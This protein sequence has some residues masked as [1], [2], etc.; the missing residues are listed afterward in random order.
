M[1]E[2]YHLLAHGLQ[3]EPELTAV[4]VARQPPAQAVQPPEVLQKAYRRVQ[5]FMW[6]PGVMAALT[7]TRR[8]TVAVTEQVAV[9]GL[10][11]LRL[12]QL[13]RLAA[14]VV[15]KVVQYLIP[16]MQHLGVVVAARGQTQARRRQAIHQIIL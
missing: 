2:A 13:L 7:L 5:P 4:L 10:A 11:G 15:A 1:L 9:E 3:L 6:L 12:D 16:A 8:E 14:Q